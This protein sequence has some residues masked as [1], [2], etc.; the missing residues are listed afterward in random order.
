MIKTIF[1]DLDGVLTTEKTGSFTTS[2]YFAE[3][4]GVNLQEVFEYKKKFDGDTDSGKI[5]D[6]DV[7]KKTCENFGV[8]NKFNADYL[9]EADL[10][11]RSCTKNKVSPNMIK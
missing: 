9:Q 1:F 2:K 11:P 3:K 7:W 8:G 6:F 10:A 4:L 5:S